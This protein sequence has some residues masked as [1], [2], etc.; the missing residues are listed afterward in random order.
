[1]AAR[2]INPYTHAPIAGPHGTAYLLSNWHHL[3]SPYGPLFTLLTEPLGVMP[4]HEAYWLWKT[5]V[6]GCALAALV[7]VALMARRLGRSP[8]RALVCAGL[9]PVTLAV[10]IGGFHND[11]PAV[12]CVLGGAAC[13][14]VASDGDK[15][16]AWDAAAGALVVLAAGIKPSFAV[17]APLVVLGSPRRVPAAAGA[18]LA[19]AA[20]ALVVLVAFDGAL[21]AVKL[22]DRLVN[23]LSVPNLLGVALGHGGADATLRTAG[24]G[25]LVVVVA[26][27]SG[28]VAWRRRWTLP[29]IGLVLLASVVSLS[30]VM[31]WYLAWALPFAALSL[32]RALIPMAVATCVWLGVAGT[33]QL[34]QLVH[35]VGWYPTRSATGHANHEYEVR[36]VK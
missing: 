26:V 21:P 36:L 16:P 31:P 4:L 18:A 27:A 35:D 34:P 19:A 7:L 10:G 9:C 25:F 1:M 17:V 5:I 14:L 32:P 2:G 23:P 15:S 28:L 6:V 3:P 22:Q 30:W 24:R 13:L 8:Q 11:M 20:V 29:A 12:L 33:P